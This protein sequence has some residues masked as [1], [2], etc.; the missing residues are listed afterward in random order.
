MYQL[1]SGEVPP[2]T[3]P[4]FGPFTGFKIGIYA[5]Q[6]VHNQLFGDDYEQMDF[7]S[8]KYHKYYA[9]YMYL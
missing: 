3:R 4:I 1:F 8:N 7:V 6:Y 5:A 2:I 9:I